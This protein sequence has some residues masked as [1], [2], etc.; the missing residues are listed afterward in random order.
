MS[1]LAGDVNNFVVGS[2][3]G[4][5]Y[6]ACRHGRYKSF[7]FLLKVNFCKYRYKF[8]F[9]ILIPISL[10]INSIIA[11]DTFVGYWFDNL[12]QRNAFFLSV[13]KLQRGQIWSISNN[14]AQFSVFSAFYYL[15]VCLYSQTKCF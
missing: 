12:E 7:M 11:F 5:V 8:V 13:S 2:E 9:V 15:F 1:F 4:M 6:T 10:N 14:Y 3:D